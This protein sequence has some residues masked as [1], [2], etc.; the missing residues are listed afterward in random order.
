MIKSKFNILTLWSLFLLFIFLLSAC[1]NVKTSVSPSSAL[2]PVLIKG[3]QEQ[4]M[5]LT[6]ATAKKAFPG[7]P[8]ERD[9]N[10][11]I[12]KIHRNWLWRGDTLMTITPTHVGGDNWLVHVSSEGVGFNGTWFDSWSIDEIQHYIN[13]LKSE[14]VKFAEVQKDNNAA[15]PASL[16]YK[17][18][19]LQTALESGLISK[20]EY[21]MKR[22]AIIDK[23]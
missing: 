12:V 21:Q 6:Y 14:Y 19:E 20:E 2:Q 9:D 8:C 7:E 4:V 1:A 16:S 23:Y 22:K 3:T 10:I 13:E 17:L 15:K 11:K 18:Q 5:D